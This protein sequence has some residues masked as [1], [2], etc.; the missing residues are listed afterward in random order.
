MSGAPLC[1]HLM[2]AELFGKLDLFP[3][4]SEESFVSVTVCETWG[5]YFV[6]SRFCAFLRAGGLRRGRSPMSGEQNPLV[7][8]P[9]LRS[10][11]FLAANQSAVESPPGCGVTSAASKETPH[12]IP[13]QGGRPPPTYSTLQ[14]LS[15]HGTTTRALRYRHSPHLR[16]SSIRLRR[17]IKQYRRIRLRFAARCHRREAF[18]RLHTALVS[19]RSQTCCS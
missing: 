10:G 18:S 2:H 4:S 6:S 12:F 5:V 8:D 7:Q 11:N 14:T 1:M 9:T 16:S 15:S 19:R 13:M 17:C 3:P